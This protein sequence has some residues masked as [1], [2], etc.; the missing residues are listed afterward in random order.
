MDLT[1]VSSLVGL[2]SR[3]FT[4]GRATLKAASGKVTKYEKACI[5]NQHV[6]IPFAFDTFGFLA[7]DAMD[8]LSRVQ[9]VMHNNLMTPRSTNVIFYGVGTKDNVENFREIRESSKEMDK[10]GVEYVDE[11]IHTG[12][13]VS[14]NS[15]KNVGEESGETGKKVNKGVFGTGDKCYEHD[16]SGVDAEVESARRLS[17]NPSVGNAGNSD[18]IIKCTKI[19][20]NNPDCDV[21]H[22]DNNNT[23]SNKKSYANKL[24]SGMNANDNELFFIPT[25]MKENGEKVVVFDEELVKEGSKKIEVYC[26]WIKNK[27]GVNYVIDQ[28]PWLVNG[29]PLSVPKWDPKIE[30]IKESP[31]KIPIW[32]RLINIPIE[33]WSDR[34]I[35][36]LASR[37]G[38]HIKM[39]QVKTDMCRVGARRLGYARVLI[40]INAE[41]KLFDKIKI[42]YV[43]DMKKVKSTKW[44]KVEYTWKP[45]RCNHCKVFGH[46]VQNSDVKPKPKPIMNNNTIA[47]DGNI[48]K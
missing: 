24:T 8:L 5:E 40:E 35:S 15:M 12:T 17:K 25:V 21:M 33:A 22:K 1:G 13:E 18:P 23:E 36:A 20:D 39:D 29:K 32:I 2:S 27:E 37:L 16:V 28:R 42:N 14:G 38:R 31:C 48:N 11:M 7:P 6:F 4:A 41:D 19:V 46:S 3:G 44:V 47:N 9:R 43:D 45:D 26:L 34:G 30:I 10:E